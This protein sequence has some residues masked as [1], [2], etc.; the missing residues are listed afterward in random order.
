MGGTTLPD[1]ET[2]YRAAVVKTVWYS[3]RER[4]RDQ[5]NKIGKPKIDPH[6]MFCGWF[7]ALF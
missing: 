4:H 3:Q 2:Y 5:R 7:L 6:G 1:M